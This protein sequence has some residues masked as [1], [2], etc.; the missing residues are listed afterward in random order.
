MILVV[1]ASGVL[2]GATARLLLSQGH[3]VRAL[4]RNPD[5]LAPLAALGAEVV[6]GDLLDP[7]SLARACAGVEQVFTTANSFLGSGASSPTRV[8]G[9]G[10]RALIDA[11]R[12]AGVRH[13]VFTSGLGV[14]AFAVVDYFRMKLET[15]AYLQ[16]S[17]LRWTVLRPSAFMEIWATIVGDPVF[18]GEPVRIVGPGTTTAN[19]VAVSDVASMAALVLSRPAERNIIIEFG[20]PDNL[21][22]LEVVAMF[23]RIAGKPARR[24]HAPG[25]LMRPMAA[26]LGLVNP[27]LGRQIKLATVAAA[28]ETSIDMA[29]VLARYPIPQTRFEDWAR[30]RHGQAARN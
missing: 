1:G 9:P 26:L 18:K 20:G 13:F 6:Q 8:D 28:T 3:A 14:E 2:G 19:Y 12:E 25:A 10:N 30:E 15:E 4:S 27:V 11:A 7:A 22:L 23:E 21:T 17:G 29:P 5:S 24:S 16:Q